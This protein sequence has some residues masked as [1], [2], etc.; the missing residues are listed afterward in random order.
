MI[1]VGFLVRLSP[2]TATYLSLQGGNFDHAD[3]KVF[4]PIFLT[5]VDVG[6][7]RD[8]LGYRERLGILLKVSLIVSLLV[9]T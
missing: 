4:P 2:F 1:A 8:V 7:R 5:I 3:R 6:L 9:W